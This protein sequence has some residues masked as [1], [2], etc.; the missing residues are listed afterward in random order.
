MTWIFLWDAAP[1]KI[2]VWDNQ[3]SKVFVWDTQVWPSGWQPWAN[4]LA[5][6]PL[7]S[8]VEEVD[9][10]WTWTYSSWT[11][12]SFWIYSSAYVDCAY[13]NS[14]TWMQYT[15]NMPFN[16]VFTISAWLYST[17]T[18]WDDWKIVDMCDTATNT[19]PKNRIPTY[20]WSWNYW[21]VSELSNGTSY[22][23]DKTVANNSRHLITF[24]SNW[25]T[26]YI[27]VDW[28]WTP[29]QTNTRLCNNTTMKSLNIG[30]Q[31]FNGLSRHFKWYMSEI[32]IENKARTAQDRITYFNQTKANYWIS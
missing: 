15:W 21:L 14:S 32:I 28:N 13:F 25:N 1:S 11:K 23:V 3:V 10:I 30:N 27:Y 8:G 6:F 26:A 16:D 31:V 2:F 29:S 18:S 20:Y 24:V 9:Q 12:A 17:W 22:S 19:N 7:N 5:Y 4:T